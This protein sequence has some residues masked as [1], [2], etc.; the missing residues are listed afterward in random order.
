MKKITLF[1]AGILFCVL[2]IA[3]APQLQWSKTYGG[4]EYEY[5]F[6]IEVCPEGYLIAGHTKSFGH[7][8]DNFDIYLIRIDDQGNELWTKTYG[9]SRNELA[10]SCEQTHDG[11]FIISGVTRS[12]GLGGSDAYALKVDRN[13][14]S[15][16]SKN[17]GGETWDQFYCGIPTLQGGY[18]FSGY[19]SVY[20]KG[21]QFYFAKTEG[22]GDTSWTYTVGG[23]NQ[24]YGYYMKQLD[25]MDYI[26]VGHTWSEGDE[27]Q[28]YLVMTDRD[29]GWNW[30]KAFGGPLEEYARWIDVTDEPGYVIVGSTQSYGH[31][32]DDFWLVNTDNEGT[33]MDTYTFGGGDSEVASGASRDV[34][35]GILIAGNTWS[36]GVEA[37]D[38]YMM[39]VTENGDSIWSLSWGGQNWE[40]AYDIKPTL[41]GGYIVVG[42]EHDIISGDYNIVV[43]KYG[44]QPLL[45]SVIYERNG[46]N[47]PIKD[48]EQTLDTITIDIPEGA[49]ILG[50]VVYLDSIIHPRV[51]DLYI[52][53]WHLDRTYGQV[54]RPHGGGANFI[55]TV[56]H[57]AASIMA[58]AGQGPMTGLYR[59]NLSVGGIAMNAD[60]NQYILHVDDASSNNEEG[61][62]HAWRLQIFYEG[63]TGIADPQEDEKVLLEV[64][65]NPCADALRLRYLIHDIRYLI[66]DLY[67]IS[68]RKIRRL[69]EEEVMPGTYKM[70]VDVSDLPAGVYFIRLQA[71]S[72]MIVKKLIVTK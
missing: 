42:R 45:N 28:V 41:D 37:T 62:L 44:S 22:D 35:G 39:K 7:A 50:M 29:G 4:S 61:T 31:G 72:S 1:F 12:W 52:K 46:L 38:M 33:P 49:N 3:Q 6:D 57:P 9:G 16:W 34:D 15:L 70:E 51:K 32:L 21:D 43:L 24:D 66:C 55:N 48:F 13:G 58:E 25:G 56:L 18:A 67:S 69:V 27:S 30:T 59:P 71:G 11:G 68:G 64:Y 23:D 53:I 54:A 65:P 36:F 5:A 26:T 19:S 10:L 63:A 2:S 17:Y 47:K 14:D 60:P 20:L 8:N 40:Y